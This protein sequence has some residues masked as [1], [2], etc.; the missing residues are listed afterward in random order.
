MEQAQCVSE[1]ALPGPRD[2]CEGDSEPEGGIKGDAQIS[3]LAK[4]VQRRR[5]TGMENMG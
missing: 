1:A 5:F 2:L 4:K 3:D